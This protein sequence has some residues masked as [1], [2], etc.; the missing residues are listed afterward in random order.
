MWKRAI[1]I[2]HVLIMILML[3]GCWNA[4]E[5]DQQ[6]NVSGIATDIGEQGRRYHICAEIV[7]VSTRG[8]SGINVYVI[9]TEGDTIFESIRN[10]MTLTSKKLYFGHCKTMIIGEEIAKYGISEILDMPIRDHELRMTMNIAVSKGCAAKEIL[11]TEGVSAPIISYKIHDMIKNC[12][13]VIGSAPYS[14]TYLVYNCIQTQGVCSVIPAVELQKIQN[15]KVLK[16]CG[17]GVFKKCKLVGFLNELQTKNLSFM[18]N[19]IRSGLLT[20]E[21]PESSYADMSFEIYKSKTKTDISFDGS[22]ITVNI[23]VKTTAGIGEVGQKANYSNFAEIEKTRNHL[24]KEMEKDFYL[25]I[26]TSQ[27]D[28][29]CD[30]FGIGMQ[31]SKHYPQKWEKYKDN[32][33]ETFP[34]VKFNVKSEVRIK[35]SGVVN[36]AA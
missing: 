10:L 15:N 6:M 7:A 33:E 3:T 18:N 30:I 35:G 20:F 25:L 32:W 13:K 9:E 12:E 36:R 21:A 23:T 31:I 26:A 4:V 28:L 16:L 22:G 14:K 2:F 11:M 27:K 5:I 17:A 24:E 29:H 1:I 34:T 19:K 8:G